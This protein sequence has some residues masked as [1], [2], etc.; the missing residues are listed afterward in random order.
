MT[1]TFTDVERG[2][3]VIKKLTS[4][5]GSAQSFAFAASYNASGFGLADGGANDSGPLK[6][7][8]YTVSEISTAG[9][10]LASATCDDGDVPGAITL[11]AGKTVTCTFT[12]QRL[13]AT[14]LMVS[15][16]A[17]PSTTRTYSWSIG[18]A[19]KETTLDAGGT[20]HYSVTVT[21]TGFKDGG[22]K[23]SGT[24]TVS[25]PN[26]AETITLTGVTDSINDGG[27]CSIT[28][29]NTTATL[30][31]KSQTGDSVTLSYSCVYSSA[32]A[33][34]ALRIG[35][36]RR[37]ARLLPGRPTALPRPTHPA[38]SPASAPR[39]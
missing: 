6:P 1:C 20:A 29:G 5:S 33:P 26:A 14:D 2:H 19:L 32:P 27:S 9:W 24:I 12:N 34:A 30:A 17:T 10:Q 39:P 23:V 21:E 15:K 8:S 16:T 38:P 31:P 25:N 7:G 18:K 4:P 13:A 36:R 28:S 22:W 35:Q 3:I 11:G 37:G